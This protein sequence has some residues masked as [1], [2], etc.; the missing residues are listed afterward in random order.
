MGSVRLTPLR[1]ISAKFPPI[2]TSQFS[3]L[4]TPSLSPLPNH[5]RRL[6]TSTLLRNS[7]R[8]LYSKLSLPSSPKT[9]QPVSSPPA[10]PL[11]NFPPWNCADKSSPAPVRPK[12]SLLTQPPPFDED[13]VNAEFQ[14]EYAALEQRSR[15]LDLE[16]Q[17]FVKE[18][19]LWIA[20]GVEPVSDEA[21]RKYRPIV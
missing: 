15:Q 12:S 9:S 17:E 2:I 10:H 3:S 18:L 21:K 13:A 5:D 11:Q 16:F 20:A 19:R 14:Q 4:N 8:R 1:Q 7:T 6:P